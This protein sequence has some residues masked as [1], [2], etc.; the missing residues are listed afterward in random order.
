MEIA[1]SEQRFFEVWIFTGLL[2]FLVCFS[3]AHV[4]NRLEKRLGNR[5]R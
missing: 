2:Y 1:I 3:L 4:F 5:Y